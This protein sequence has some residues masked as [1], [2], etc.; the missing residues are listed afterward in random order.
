MP[1]GLQL[2]VDEVT[3]CDLGFELDSKI[4]LDNPSCSCSYSTVD[5]GDRSANLG[6]P[7][8]GVPRVR[9]EVSLSSKLH[10]ITIRF[11]IDPGFPNFS[12]TA[13]TWQ[14]T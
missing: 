13:G 4:D 2:G 5:I 1:G 14:A 7:G 3:S 10:G 9:F 11:T 6:F 8:R 12:A